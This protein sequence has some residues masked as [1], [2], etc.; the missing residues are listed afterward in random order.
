MKR[1]FSVA[2]DGVSVYGATNMSPD[3]R[4]AFTRLFIVQ[5]KKGK[6]VHSFVKDLKAAGFDVGLSTMYRWI[7]D[8]ETTGHVLSVMKSSGAEP[9]LTDEQRLI[10][11]GY[12]FDLCD[13]HE[14]VHLQDYQSAALSFFGVD[15]SSATA[16]RYLHMDGF[17]S[18]VVGKKSAGYEYS[19]D[20]L[21][22][23]A[24]EWV[25]DLR[26]HSV[27]S[28]PDD[29]LCSVDFTF[30]S[31][32]T[33]RATS[34]CPVG[35]PQPKCDHNVPRYTNCIVTCV[36]KD[37]VNRT[38]PVL[39]T[40]NQKFRF[41]RSKT[42]LRVKEEGELLEVLGRYGVD[43]SRVVYVGSEKGEKRT[44]VKESADLMRLFFTKYPIVT[45]CTLLSDGGHACAKACEFGF[46]AHLIYPSAVHQF[47][48]PNDNRLHGTAKAKW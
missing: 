41:D 4:E 29:K 24:L 47:L 23:L 8:Y 40:Y 34:F 17:C 37:G 39:Y 5:K 43:R 13:S 6:A 16:G 28:L 18:K 25:D 33:Q 30:T 20:Q 9:K 3:V 10:L 46:A 44:Y 14:E 27:F 21:T 36:W 12:V 35:S 48:S 7:A 45:G 1:D 19:Q 26:K 31:H 22:R 11:A 15:I 38:P 42:A 2:D 32:R